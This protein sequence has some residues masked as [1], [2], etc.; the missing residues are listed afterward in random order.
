[1]TRPIA[2]YLRRGAH[3]LAGMLE[4]DPPEQGEPQGTIVVNGF[5]ISATPED[6]KPPEPGQIFTRIRIRTIKTTATTETDDDLFV[7]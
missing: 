7:V 2:M 3:L 4:G 1:M 5:A 6:R